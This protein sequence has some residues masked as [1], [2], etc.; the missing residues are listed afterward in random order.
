MSRFLR[1]FELAIEAEGQSVVVKPPMRITFTCD[2]SITG[3]LNKLQLQIYNLK[4][5]NRLAIVKDAEE[6]KRI[7]IILK[8]GYEWSSEVIF[9]GTVHRGAN[10]RQGADFIS[11]LE[12]LDGGED[13]LASF[14]SK[15][16][17][18]KQAAVEEIL[19]DLPNT[20]KGKLTEQITLLRP[21]VLIGN[22]L[23]LIEKALAPNETYYIDNEQLFIIKDDEVISSYIPLVSAKTGLLNTP[24]RESKKVSFE[25]L[26]N[27][28]LKLGGLCKLKS[29]LAPHL[30]GTYKIES[31]SYS[32]D[33]EGDDWK[34]SVTCIAAGDYKVL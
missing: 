2:K 14:T 27:P 9:Q 8:V 13:Y 15:V 3:G 32:G 1:D 4:E 33:N 16:V 11:D 25:T 34:Q 22:S 28:T 5:S 30:D 7:P 23:Q 12:C 26:M 18:G 6:R 24:E 10:Q 19:K 20:K 29:V 21:K 17:K 31:M